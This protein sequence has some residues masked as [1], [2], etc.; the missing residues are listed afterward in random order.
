MARPRS[1]EKRSAIL[2]AATL[3]FDQEGISAP[4][5]RIARQ[6]GVAEGSLFT[7]FETKDELLNALYLELKTELRDARMPGY[8]LTE[9]RRSRARHAWRGFVAWGVAHPH[10]RQVINVLG[11]SE[12]VTEASK[13]AG[14]LAF[15][16]LNAMLAE[17]AQAGPMRG[18]P[19]AFVGRLMTSMAEATM[20]FIERA[21]AD[22]ELFQDAGFEAFWRA[23]GGDAVPAVSPL[24]DKARRQGKSAAAGS[25]ALKAKPG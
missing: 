21:P 10:K 6:A 11:L 13:T 3:V 5:A 24:V 9:S 17:A 16:A 23:V 14:M 15:E 7:K 12:R 25:R 22:A 1:E 19:L 8:P 4:T 2:E 20:D 18:Q